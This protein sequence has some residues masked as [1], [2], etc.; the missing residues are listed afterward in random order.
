[1]P[2]IAANQ[3]DCGSKP[4]WINSSRD[5]LSKKPNTQK[6]LVE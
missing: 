5:L 1:M 4:A 2:E 3:E 6:G